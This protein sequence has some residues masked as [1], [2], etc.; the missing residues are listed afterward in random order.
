MFGR[1]KKNEPTPDQPQAQSAQE[2]VQE[3]QQAQ[4]ATAASADAGAAAA[5]QRPVHDPINGE[6]GPFDG[7]E[8]DF[9]EYDFSDFAKGGLDL[10][11]MMVPVPH[12]GEVQVE[13]GPQGP[14][15][16]H[17]VTPYG[18][19]TPVAFAAPRND[20]LWAE[21]VPEIVEGMGKDGLTATVEQG[22]WGDE[23]AAVAGNGAMRII[24]ASG[25]RWMLRVT[26]A[27]PSDSA[28]DLAKM[29]R[30]IVA[31][32]F[33]NRGSDPIPAGSPLPVEMPQAMAEEL[34]KQMAELAA[35]QEQQGQ[36]PQQGQQNPAANPEQNG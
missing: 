32:T 2:T 29:G 34:Q 6:F 24:G 20:D 3:S 22:P 19:V 25:P 16:I 31:R 26:L 33:V 36:Q 15:M 8:V 9:R 13:M 5:A 10:A 4:Q 7:D 12:E 23:I 21:S 11:S 27:G 18:R 1:K 14:Q 28:E 35:Q 30:E 17:I